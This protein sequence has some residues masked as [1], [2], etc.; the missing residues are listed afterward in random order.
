MRERTESGIDF[1]FVYIAFRAAAINKAEK[2]KLQHRQL[3]S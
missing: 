3:G 2:S 1:M